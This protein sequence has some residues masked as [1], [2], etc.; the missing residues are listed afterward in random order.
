M[1]FN[2]AFQGLEEHRFSIFVVKASK[3]FVYDVGIM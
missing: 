1:G 2:S 3:Y